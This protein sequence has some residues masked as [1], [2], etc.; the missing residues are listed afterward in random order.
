MLHFAQV[1][2][3]YNRSDMS[4]LKDFL[5]QAVNEANNARESKLA[6]LLSRLRDNYAASGRLSAG[7]A[8]QVAKIYNGYIAQY[9]W[10]YPFFDTK[11]PTVVAPGSQ[12]Y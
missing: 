9:A 12:P 10:A 3:V 2:N 6:G 11:D 1:L 5:Q 7:I 4:L 8:G